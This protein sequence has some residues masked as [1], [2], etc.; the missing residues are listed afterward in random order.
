MFVG[1]V[2]IGIG[3]AGIVGDVANRIVDIGV[4]VGAAAG[5]VGT[6]QTI[7]PVVAKTLLLAAVDG[8]EQRLDVARVV[9]GVGQLLAVVVERAVDVSS[10]ASQAGSMIQAHIR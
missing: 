9:I 10:T 6:G 4:V 7:Q 2:A 5:G 8:V 1:S 3:V